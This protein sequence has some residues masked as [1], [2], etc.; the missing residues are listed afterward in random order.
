MAIT[1]IVP[2]INYLHNASRSSL[3]SFEL[4]RL[5]HAANL[6]REIAAL[7]DQWLEETAEAM[8]ARWM[9]DHHGSLRQPSLSDSDILGTFQDPGTAPLPN[10]PEPPVDIRAAPPHFAAPRHR[11][12]GTHGG[13]PQK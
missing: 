7:I 1:R 11:I 5:N 4:A 8:L 9:L 3:Q 13:K 6:R 2:P 10:A 12:T